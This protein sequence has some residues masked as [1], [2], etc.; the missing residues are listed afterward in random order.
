MYRIYLFPITSRAIE[1]SFGADD[2]TV[3]RAHDTTDIRNF[4]IVAHYYY[5]FRSA[6]SGREEKGTMTTGMGMSSAREKISKLSRN[7]LDGVG[8]SVRIECR[9]PPCGRTVVFYFPVTSNTHRDRRPCLLSRLCETRSRISSYARIFGH[10][11]R[12]TRTE[13]ATRTLVVTA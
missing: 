8:T 6:L 1:K 7:T 5:N 2:E 4:R 13:K 9:N 10:E 3:R 12:A 11:S